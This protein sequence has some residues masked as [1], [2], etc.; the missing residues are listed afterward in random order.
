MDNAQKK[1]SIYLRFKCTDACN[2]SCPFCHKEGFKDACKTEMSVEFFAR[3]IKI[4]V[5]IGLTRVKFTGGEPTLCEKLSE[6]ISVCQ[7]YDEVKV[8][9]VSNGSRPEILKLLQKQFPL[10]KLSVS[11]PALDRDEYLR[12]TGGAIFGKNYLTINRFAGKLNVSVNHI[13]LNERQ[14]SDEWFWQV[15]ELAKRVSC[16][17]L[18]LPCP[19]N[20]EQ[21]QLSKNIFEKLHM[22][23]LNKTF[24]EIQRE[25]NKIRYT[26]EEIDNIFIVLPYCPW[27]CHNSQYLTLRLSSNGLIKRCF[28]SDAECLELQEKMTDEEIESIILKV[29]NQQCMLQMEG[30]NEIR[31]GV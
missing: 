24:K 28:L 25:D 8:A 18:L 27:V 11:L 5:K 16:V 6:Y 15:I 9:V 20:D 14:I 23:L 30:A 12:L 10:L 19:Q 3:I 17:K 13:V 22:F 1:Q 2:L 4:L 7:N 31:K 29:L 26:S 21:M